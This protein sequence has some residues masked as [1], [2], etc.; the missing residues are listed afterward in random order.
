[1]PVDSLFPFWDDTYIV[2]DT[3]QGIF[4]Q[5]S[6]GTDITV[7]FQLTRFPGRIEDYHYTVFYSTNRPGIFTFTYYRVS[8]GGIS[9]TIG[10]QY[11]SPQIA[12]QFSVNS[13]T[14]T[15]G[16]VLTVDTISGT[17]TQS[18]TNVT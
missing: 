1:M 6:G 4:Y 5:I 18:T 15:P 17:I 8:D 16:L 10:A 12:L 9:A 13:A 11:G 2:E 14:L 3:P 7:D